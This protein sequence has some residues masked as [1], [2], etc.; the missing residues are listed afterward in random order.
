MEGNAKEFNIGDKV[1]YNK[2]GKSILFSNRPEAKE[3]FECIIY[4]IVV[5]KYLDTTVVNWL[6]HKGIVKI[7]GW[8]TTTR[9]LESYKP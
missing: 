7:E 3:S 2:T 5:D 9:L 4:G 8:K 1:I 6:N